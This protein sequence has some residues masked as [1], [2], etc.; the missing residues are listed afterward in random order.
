QPGGSCPRATYTR[1]AWGPARGLP[2]IRAEPHGEIA[3]AAA[4]HLDEPPRQGSLRR[5]ATGGRHDPAARWF[6]RGSGL[7]DR[8]EGWQLPAPA[9]PCPPQPPKREPPPPHTP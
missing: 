9:P 2:T 5:D 3:V 7:L 6:R 1:S 4:R 8:H